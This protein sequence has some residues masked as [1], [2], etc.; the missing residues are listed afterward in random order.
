MFSSLVFHV[1]PQKDCVMLPFQGHFI[2]SALLQRLSEHYPERAAEWHTENTIKPFTVSTLFPQQKAIHK[3]V[4]FEKSKEYFI[5]LTLIECDDLG[6][7]LDVFWKNPSITLGNESFEIKKISTTPQQHP[8]AF[9]L[10]F[11]AWKVKAMEYSTQDVFSFH[12]LSPTG[13]RSGERKVSLLPE[14]EKIFES[15]HLKATKLGILQQPECIDFHKALW[16]R[17][18]Q[19]LKTKVFEI[20]NISHRGFLGNVTFEIQINDSEF[21]Q[22]VWKLVFLAPF[23]GV[24]MKT[25]FGMGQVSISF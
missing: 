14:P 17:E 8:L 6:K 5:R 23:L 9:F 2:Y 16:I 22:Y 1:S 4:R 3:S 19:E 7:I 25:T 24:G 10:D 18:I 11:D 20:K 13:F 15:L 12:F 21:R